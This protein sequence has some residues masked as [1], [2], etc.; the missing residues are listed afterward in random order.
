MASPPG[1]DGSERVDR[2]L[3]Q[4]DGDKGGRRRSPLQDPLDKEIADALATGLTDEEI[5]AMFSGRATDADLQR[6]LGMARRGKPNDTAGR[7]ARLVNARRLGFG[8]SILTGPQ[9]VG[10]S[11]VSRTILGGGF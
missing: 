2:D 11:P 4:R 1:R 8:E 9:G 5:L 6:R 7:Q 3:S 10:S